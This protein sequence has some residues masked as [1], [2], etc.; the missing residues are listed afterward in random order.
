MATHPLKQHFDYFFGCINPSKAWVDKAASIYSGVTR[1]LEGAGGRTAVLRPNLF[2]QGSYRRDTAIYTINDIDIVALCALWFPGE[3]TG[4]GWSRDEI[5]SALA[6]PFQA[7]QLYSDKVRYGPTSLCI[8]LDLGIDVEILP[9]VFKRGTH[10]PTVEPF[11]IYRPEEQKWVHAFAREHHSKLSAKNKATEG[12]LIPAIK[13]MKHIRSFHGLN[14]VSFHLESF[15]YAQSSR[16]F[17][18]SPAD[19]FADLLAVIATLPA[20]QWWQSG[21]TTPCG[22]RLLFS[23]S[24]WSLL[25]WTHFYRLV[26]QLAPIAGEAVRTADRATAV[27][28]WQRVL[29]E[30]FFPTYQQ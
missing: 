29:G 24:E 4:N 2:L 21:I 13:T 8:K 7:N 14:T 17:V 9:A 27:R 6:A 10:D 20:E 15:L 19:V 23:P 18:G 12:N 25:S 22:D 16:C 11:C 5:F 1:V 28:L 30:A 26:L 3:G